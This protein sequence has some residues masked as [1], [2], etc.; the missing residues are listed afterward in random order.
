MKR[1]KTGGGPHLSPLTQG[2]GTF[3][4]L[5]DEEPHLC[6]VLGGIDTNDE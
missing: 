3:L 6:G 4:R 2:E 5:A 1:P